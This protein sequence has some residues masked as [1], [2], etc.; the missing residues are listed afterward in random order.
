MQRELKK[1]SK[2]RIIS[3]NFYVNKEALDYL[4]LLMVH[5]YNCFI[6]HDQ[7]SD[8]QKIESFWG[9]MLNYWEQW[10]TEK[11]NIITFKK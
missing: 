4:S 8:I 7:L 1:N 10:T 3:G 9:W 5:T 6:H 11:L 2:D